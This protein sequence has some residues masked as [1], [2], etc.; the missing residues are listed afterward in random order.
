VK[1]GKK[2]GIGTELALGARVQGAARTVLAAC[3]YEGLG[4]G[5]E[6]LERAERRGY[7][8]P[9][10]EDVVRAGYAHY[11]ATRASLIGVLA[12]LEPECGRVADDW[13]L[14]RGAFAVTLAA[15]ALLARGSRR[16][17]ALGGRSRVLRKKLDEPDLLRGVP[18]KTFARLYHAATLR[19]RLAK[20]YEAIVW[21]QG[22]R[23][24][25]DGLSDGGELGEIL[26]ILD[27]QSAGDLSR[28][29]FF[30]DRLRYRWFSFRRRHHSAWKKSVFELFRFSG[31]MISELRQPGAKSGSGIK[32]VT[33]EQSEA[34][35]SLARPGD[36]FITR[37]DDALSNLF[38]PGYWPHAAL[39][40][41]SEAQRCERGMVLEDE[42]EFLAAAR[43]LEAKK[44]GVL[45]R[46]ADDTLAVDALVVLRPP[47]GDQEITAALRRALEHEGKLYDFVFD[48]RRSDR[49][50]CTEVVYRAF[51]DCGG[52]EFRLKEVSG[53]LCLPA[54]ELIHQALEQGFEVVLSCGIGSG[55]L[56][57]GRA[58]ELALHSSRAGI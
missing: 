34:V 22:N 58:A 56:L 45:L 9:T 54:E 16:A 11:L 43:F 2:N 14:R 10:E 31:S 12:E 57:R 3:E 21:F 32:R 1:F 36:V 5:W 30:R 53:R 37:H 24:E 20:F 15:A 52:L 46:T 40:I 48:F 8:T 17:V 51:Y 7:L 18:P 23:A 44:D 39:F 35:L 26:R 38:L 27:A 41:G 55:G 33:A 6:F 19:H 47:L 50:A 49:L 4:E 29:L 13:R 25:F 42:V 28:R